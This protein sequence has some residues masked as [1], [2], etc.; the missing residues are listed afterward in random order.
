MFNY[1]EFAHENAAKEA[2]NNSNPEDRI[3]IVVKCHKTEKELFYYATNENL[4]PFESFGFCVD[5]Q[6]PFH[7]DA[8]R[9]LTSP[10]EWPVQYEGRYCE[11]C[12]VKPDQAVA[13]TEAE[14]TDLILAEDDGEEEEG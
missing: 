9:G 7:V 3:V 6:H 14:K 11:E 2:R 12:Y 10:T 5:C 8:L 1:K 4:Y 13:L